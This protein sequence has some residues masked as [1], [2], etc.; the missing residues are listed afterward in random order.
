MFLNSKLMKEE[1]GFGKK[2]T[3]LTT[4][5]AF[6][7]SVLLDWAVVAV[8]IKRIQAIM[9]IIRFNET[10]L[11]LLSAIY[12]LFV[13]FL[14][15]EKADIRKPRLFIRSFRNLIQFLQTLVNCLKIRHSVFAFHQ[16]GVLNNAFFVNDKCTPLRN[17]FHVKYPVFK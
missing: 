6:P 5:S 4:L 12:K 3:T 9:V 7:A 1:A 14:K 16:F 15:N 10:N 8:V 13:T 17:P 11:V 2:R